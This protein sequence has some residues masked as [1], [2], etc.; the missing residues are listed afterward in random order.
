MCT[1]QLGEYVGSKKFRDSGRTECRVKLAVGV[2]DKLVD[3]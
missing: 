1:D 2:A 3:R